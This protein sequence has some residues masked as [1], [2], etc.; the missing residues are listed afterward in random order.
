MTKT[1]IIALLCSVLI[2]GICFYFCRDMLSTRIIPVT[3]S[4]QSNVAD[5]FIF[6]AIYSH[7]EKNPKKNKTETKVNLKQKLILNKMNGSS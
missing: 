2:T 4:V 6:T 1:K 5:E 3:F 7:D